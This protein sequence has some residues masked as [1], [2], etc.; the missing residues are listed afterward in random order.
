MRARSKVRKVTARQTESEVKSP[1]NAAPQ[2]SPKPKAAY[3]RSEARTEE[4]VAEVKHR[5]ESSVNHWRAFRESFTGDPGGTI[6]PWVGG[7]AFRKSAFAS[8]A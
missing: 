5:R 4:M 1:A 6:F 7:K 3:E 2:A 8:D